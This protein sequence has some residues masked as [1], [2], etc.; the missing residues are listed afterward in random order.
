MGLMIQTMKKI[1]KLAVQA[2]INLI[3]ILILQIHMQA[4]E[5]ERKVLN[6]NAERNQSLKLQLISKTPQG[7]LKV[8]QPRRKKKPSL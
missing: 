6:S 2:E 8:A 7:Q 1:M 4:K 5:E 3:V